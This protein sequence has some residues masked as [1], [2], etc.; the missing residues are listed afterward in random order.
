MNFG[1]ERFEEAN[2]PRSNSKGVRSQQLPAKTDP[3]V[4]LL[5]IQTL[6]SAKFRSA[7]QFA[8]GLN[9]S[10]RLVSPHAS[11]TTIMAREEQLP[12]DLLP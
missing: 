12:L 4:G 8:D 6:Q 9:G 1:Y 5:L 10:C 3:L 2:K 11:G 7:A